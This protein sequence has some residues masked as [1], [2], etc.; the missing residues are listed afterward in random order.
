ML[1]PM[2]KPEQP[3]IHFVNCRV[4]FGQCSAKKEPKSSRKKS[5]YYRV[6]GEKASR[7]S[8]NFWL[9][10]SDVLLWIAC[11]VSWFSTDNSTVAKSIGVKSLRIR[12]QS[13]VTSHG[14][15]CCIDL[16]RIVAL[17]IPKL[18]SRGINIIRLTLACALQKEEA[19][20]SCPE[21]LA[22]FFSLCG[23]MACAMVNTEYSAFRTVST[24]F[25]GQHHFFC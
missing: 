9:V 7:A 19:M 2:R 8:A 3:V 18:C 14:P 20:Q 22:P 25:V 10:H 5:L 6:A 23:G 24:Q 15:S 13:G 11:F 16:L 12:N 17:L 1:M 4:C 21:C